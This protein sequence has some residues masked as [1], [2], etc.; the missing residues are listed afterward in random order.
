MKNTFFD[1]LM[2]SDS[3]RIHTQTLAWIISLD[4]SVFPSDNKKQFL[5]KLFNVNGEIRFEQKIYVETEFNK[6]DLFIDTDNYQFLL[7]NK[8]KSSEHSNQTF[9][10]ID[11]IPSQFEDAN[12]TRI[13]GFLTLVKDEAMNP[14]WIPISFEKLKDSLEKLTW[15][16]SQKETVFIKEYIQTL[17]NLTEVYNGFIDNHRNYANVFTDGSKKKYEKE[18]YENDLQDYIR[19]NQLETIFQKAFLKAV[20]KNAKIEY[21]EIGETR[22]TALFQ[23]HI[24]EI[25]IAGEI[26]RLGFQFQGKT[27]KINLVHKNYADSKP[28]Q[29]GEKLMK[30]FKNVFYQKNNYNTLNKPRKKAYV[31]VSKILTNE[32]FDIDKSALIELF[33]KEI[34]YSNV[35]AKEFENLI[36]TEY[37]NV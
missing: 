18:S 25:N 30:I 14:K 37:K 22:G 26:F 27:M 19:R 13:Y 7:E 10:Y 31:S 4:D 24:S 23:T 17:G 8:L 35:K 33:Q 6:I 9:R 34:K 16:D 11:A 5:S 20:L 2:I 32:I 3:E 15:N 21:I 1:S 12:K 29:V 28:E 36:N